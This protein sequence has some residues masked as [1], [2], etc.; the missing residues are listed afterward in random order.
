MSNLTSGME[1]EASNNFG[2][3]RRQVVVVEHKYIPSVHN[4]SN[5]YS[6]N[7]VKASLTSVPTIQTFRFEINL[8]EYRANS[9]I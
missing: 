6:I 5:K 8:L 7:M 4:K 1:V 2:R 3:I 9:F